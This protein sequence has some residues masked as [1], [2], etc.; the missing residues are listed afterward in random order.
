MKFVKKLEYLLL[1]NEGKRFIFAG[2]M[3]FTEITHIF[4]PSCPTVWLYLANWLLRP[5]R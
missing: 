1:Q 5:V 4:H 3:Q 2:M